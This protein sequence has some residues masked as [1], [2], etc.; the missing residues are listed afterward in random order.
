MRVF[1]RVEDNRVLTLWFN[2]SA[3]VADVKA[4]CSSARRS[5]SDAPCTSIAIA[6]MRL[7]HGA[8]ELDD[9]E[10]LHAILAAEQRAT[11]RA[12][13]AV[14][15]TVLRRR[16]R[17]LRE[18]GGSAP[19]HPVHGATDVALAAAVSITVRCA[20]EDDVDAAASSLALYERSDQR[21]PS[22]V[23]VT[24][25]GPGMCTLTLTP[26]RP[27]CSAT[28]FVAYASGAAADFEWE[29]A[30]V[31]LA[32]VRAIGV[33]VN[34]RGSAVAPPVLITLERSGGGSLWPELIH[35]LASRARVTPSLIR[36]CAHDDAT[37]AVACDER[38]V[39]ALVADQRVSFRV[40]APAVAAVEAAV[41]AETKRVADE[42]TT[43]YS[44]SDYCEDH[45]ATEECG[46]YA[47]VGKMSAEEEHEALLSVI[48][49][50]MDAS[51]F[52]AT[53]L[54]TPVPRPPP[55][56]PAC[57]CDDAVVPPSMRRKAWQ[58]RS[59]TG[60]EPASSASTPCTAPRIFELPAA[61]APRG[62]FGASVTHALRMNGFFFLRLPPSA[63][64]AI[65]A[66]DAAAETFWRLPLASKLRC[67]APELTRVLG[68][69][70]RQTEFGKELFVVRDLQRSGAAPNLW[71]REL[72][73][74]PYRAAAERAYAT[75]LALGSALAADVIAALCVGVHGAEDDEASVATL[76][77]RVAAAL[78][79]TS[80]AAAS[81]CSPPPPLAPH[82][83]QQPF[84]SSNLSLFKYDGTGLA[85]SAVNCPGH[86]D[87]GLLTIIPR[88]CGGSG[89]HAFSWC[90]EK[91][92]D[93]EDGAPTDGVCVVLA[94]EQLTRV[95]NGAVMATMHEVAGCNVERRSF[96]FQLLAR[97]NAVLRS[98]VAT[99]EGGGDGGGGASRGLELQ[100][101]LVGEQRAGLARGVAAQAYVHAISAAR[102]SSNF[103]K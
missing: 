84:S 68:Y 24:H 101:A 56:P 50:F 80:F 11:G 67:S 10:Q 73:G 8:R 100:G 69:A 70:N 93:L 29:F 72:E 98:V 18:D 97:P 14:L 81:S 66:L 71:P 62:A 9:G 32:P 44:Y 87:V 15:K 83:Q 79:E 4:A 36:I 35:K 48:A 91:W 53:K 99:G 26:L 59:N 51:A 31:A 54:S 12:G 16:R 75:M 37:V 82:Q 96:P 39:A 58:R 63:V 42:A 76:R 43:A 86:T 64:C 77:H 49:A 17:T 88:S 65:T 45:F 85:T 74:G 89:L 103:P 6:A 23:D 21:V 5:R 19:L 95:T 78:L 47:V 34:A 13:Y 2:E 20:D 41:A 52:G 38:W 25:C 40:A 7:L 94:G 28:S 33:R 102:T 1:V 3:V 92:L 57:G 60:A 30:T 55:H 90:E 46:Y 61:G 22:R 27:L